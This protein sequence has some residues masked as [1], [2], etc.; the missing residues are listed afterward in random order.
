MSKSNTQRP[1]TRPPRQFLSATAS[2]HPS[3]APVSPERHNRLS[4]PSG[5]RS[6]PP[7]RVAAAGRGG[8]SVNSTNPQDLNYKISTF[9]EKSR[10]IRQIQ[11]V[12]PK[13]TTTAPQ[14]PPGLHTKNTTARLTHK[15]PP[16]SPQIPKHS[17][18][19]TQGQTLRASATRR[20]RAPVLR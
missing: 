12:N 6:N 4:G 17:G 11:M 18:S 10:K 14:K 20:G 8:S 9:F 3:D 2:S 5:R 13:F 15:P 1:K 16:E 19:N 7:N